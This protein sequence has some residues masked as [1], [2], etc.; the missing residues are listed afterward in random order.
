MEDEDRASSSG[1]A[2]SSSS[3]FSDIDEAEQKSKPVIV[4]TAEDKG[5]DSGS[6]SSSGGSSA[7]GA[8]SKSDPDDEDDV[9]GHGASGGADSLWEPARLLRKSYPTWDSRFV[10]Y[11]SRFARVRRG[12]RREIKLSKEEDFLNMDRP[13]MF[14][15]DMTNYMGIWMSKGVLKENCE[16]LNSVKLSDT[17][18]VIYFQA[19]DVNNDVPN[20]AIFEAWYKSF[21]NRKKLPVKLELPAPQPADQSLLDVEYYMPMGDEWTFSE[22]PLDSQWAGGSQFLGRVRVFSNQTNST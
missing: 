2:S 14:V 9:L 7:D 5:E 4:A 15:S 18:K 13:D 19:D 11:K 8:D 16:P 17:E 12:R 3:E 6:D 20:S 10:N 21:V 1:A 22:N